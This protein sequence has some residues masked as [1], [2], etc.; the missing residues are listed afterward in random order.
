MASAA[1]EHNFLGRL[2]GVRFT[3]LAVILGELLAMLL[4]LAPGVVV[5]DRWTHFGVVSLFIQWVVLLSLGIICTLRRPLAHVGPAAAGLVIIALAMLTTLGFSLAPGRL[6]AGPGGTLGA[7]AIL[8]H[9]AIALL[10][11][12][13]MA[14]YLYVQH[15]WRHNLRARNRA[16]L[17]ELQSRFRPHFLFN[18][19]NAVANLVRTRPADAE[20]ALLDLADVFRTLATVPD[21]LPLAEDIAL[22]RRYLNL[23]KLR[24]GD[25]LTVDWSLPEKLEAIEVPGVILQPLLENAV[26]HGIETLAGGGTI[27]VRGWHKGDCLHFSVTNPVGGERQRPGCGQGLENVRRRLALMETG[28]ARLTTEADGDRYRV[29]LELPIEP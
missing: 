6:L 4:T 29:H 11:S 2:C 24:L 20:A 1:T 28:P 17:R 25:R 23:E 26:R 13:A 12:T 10:V 5:A 27:R 3:L 21:T 8:R 15:V 7:E 18:S 19:L 16:E 22:A 9:L 14:R